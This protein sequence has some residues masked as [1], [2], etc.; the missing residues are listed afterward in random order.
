MDHGPWHTQHTMH[1]AL[2]HAYGCGLWVVVHV[3]RI[4][5]WAVYRVY[6][7]VYMLLVAIVAC[8]L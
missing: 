8:G 3:V 4:W 2:L 6:Q 5:L 1:I 7:H